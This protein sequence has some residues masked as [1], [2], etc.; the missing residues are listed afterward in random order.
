VYK[1]KAYK[2]FDLQAFTINYLAVR[3]GLE[4]EFAHNLIVRL[5]HRPKFFL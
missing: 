5:L 3:T 2:S 4:P 1:V